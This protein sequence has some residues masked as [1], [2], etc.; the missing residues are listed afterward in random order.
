MKVQLILCAAEKADQAYK[1]HCELVKLEQEH[2]EL[3]DN[4]CWTIQRQDAYERFAS[5]FMEVRNDR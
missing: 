3:K 5:A 1:V 2:P 4:P